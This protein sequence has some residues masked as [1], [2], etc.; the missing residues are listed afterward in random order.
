MKH[1]FAIVFLIPLSLSAEVSKL[2]YHGFTLWF[3]CKARSAVRFQY[4]LD[5]DVG[6]VPRIKKYYHDPM[7]E[8]Y[9]QQFETSSYNTNKNIEGYNRGRLVPYNHMDHSL[10]ASHQTNYMTNILPQTKEM[11]RGA[12][13]LTEE[14]TECFRDYS[15]LIILGGPIWKEEITYLPLH[16]V[17]IPESFWK[18]IIRNNEVIAWIIPNS[19]EATKGRLDDYLVSVY[20][21]EQITDNAI[22]IESDKK[23]TKQPES[24]DIGYCEKNSPKHWRGDW[25]N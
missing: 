12:W 19:K 22:S 4:E 10:I 5:R 16:G 8:P 24:W 6:A 2:E 7:L 21:I 23:R 9:C 15:R 20:E 13:H 17:S 14:I 1:L 3:D 25:R 18:V 11:N